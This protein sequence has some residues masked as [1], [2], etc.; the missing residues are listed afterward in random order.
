[1][2]VPLYISQMTFITRTSC[3][4]AQEKLG[5]NLSCECCKGSSVMKP[6]NEAL[7]ITFM[8]ILQCTEQDFSSQRKMDNEYQI[9]TW[10]LRHSKLE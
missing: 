4:R 2:T 9:L 5:R 8:A 1:M 6:D 10:L 7:I 3:I